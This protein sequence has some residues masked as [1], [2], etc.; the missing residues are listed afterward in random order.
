MRQSI[1]QQSIHF[2]IPIFS[3]FNMFNLAKSVKDDLQ[4]FLKFIVPIAI[5]LSVQVND[6]KSNFNIGVGKL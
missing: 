3:I 4:C 6:D 2:L 1:L 5:V